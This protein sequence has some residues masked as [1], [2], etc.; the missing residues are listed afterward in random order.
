MASPGDGAEEGVGAGG[1]QGAAASPRVGD[2]VYLEVRWRQEAEELVP[3]DAVRSSCKHGASEQSFFCY[4][5]CSYV[6]SQ[7]VRSDFYTKS[8]PYTGVRVA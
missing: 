7:V 5:C 2:E 8:A 1:A 3:E 4:R 6:P